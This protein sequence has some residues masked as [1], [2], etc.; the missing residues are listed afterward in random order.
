MDQFQDSKEQELL[1]LKSLGFDPVPYRMVTFETLP[2]AEKAFTGQVF[3][4]DDL[5]KINRVK[6]DELPFASLTM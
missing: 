1:W 2:E 6:K 3:V 5:E 4:P